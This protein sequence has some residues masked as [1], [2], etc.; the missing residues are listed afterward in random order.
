[1][2]L[3]SYYEISDRNGEE[4]FY[5]VFYN[6]THYHQGFLKEMY[7]RPLMLQYFSVEYNTIL[8]GLLVQPTQKVDMMFTQTVSL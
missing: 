7:N 6:N 1:M 5:P 3:F 2:F 4:D 8:K